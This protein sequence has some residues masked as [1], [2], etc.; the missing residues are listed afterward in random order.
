MNKTILFLLA[1]GL[2]PLVS[3]QTKEELNRKFQNTQVQNE[4]KFDSY[5]Q[6]NN[7]TD[8]IIIKKL[9][10][11]LAG[12]AGNQ[13]V[14]WEVDDIRGNRAANIPILQD[15]TMPGLSGL[16]VDGDGQNIIVMD[17]GKVFEKHVDFGAS[18]AGVVTIPRVFDMENGATSYNFHATNCAGIIGSEGIAN[19]N[20]LGVLQKIKINSYGFATTVN[21]TNY[22]KLNAAPGANISN[23]SYG[24][25]LGWAYR[26][27]PTAGWYWVSDYDFSTTDTYSGSYGD[28][29]IAFD[30]IVYSNPEQIVVKSSGNYYGDGPSGSF[31]GAFKQNSSGS[32]VP[33]LSTDVI[34]PNNCSLGYNCIGWGSLAKNIIVAGAA[35]QLTTLGNVYS[36]PSDV[37]AASFSSA[38]PRKDGAIKPDLSAV[39]VDMRLT[40]YSS[41][42]TYNSTSTGS[43]TSYSA[44][45]ITGV[46]GAL[47]Q[48]KR[49]LSANTTFKFKADE[50]KALLTH[51]ANEAGPNPGPDVSFGWGFVDAKAGA[52]LLIDNNNNL[53]IFQ[54]RTLTSGVPYTRVVKAVAG[55]P[56]KVSISWID[57]A[58]TSFTT[59]NDLQ[60]NRTSKLVNDMDLKI[61]DMVT[62]QEYLPW[63][64]DALNPVAAATKGNNTVDNIEQVL[65]DAPVAERLYRIEVSNKGTLVNASGTPTPQNYAF[66]ATGYDPSYILS[67]SETSLKDAIAIYPTMVEDFLTIVI[68]GKADKISIFD[69]SG[70]IIFSDNARGQQ[71]INFKD[72]PAGVYMVNIE[73]KDGNY[74]ERVIKK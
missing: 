51:T 60:N 56:L 36:S 33:F 5:A 9:K 62:N 12:F 28:Q 26:T 29:D 13:P 53:N 34:P 15:G 55:K 45:I 35:N 54:R 48:I 21:G 24:I 40:N 37:S 1:M 42:T 30:Q 74:S 14:F 46:A 11:N 73:T 20:T 68:S 3:A 43:G 64:L 16:I 2:S 69:M 39:G 25:N 22:A 72:V 4:L 70:K 66:I 50:M 6:R 67:T 49:S 61:V 27:S 44:P 19:T 63:K 59:S 38:G 7:I 52:Q 47:T 8:P 58:G 32:Y 65:I 17:G 23:H 57:P 71:L 18:T 10:S 31:S 41:S